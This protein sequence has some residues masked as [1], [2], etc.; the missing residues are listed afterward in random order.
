MKIVFTAQGTTWD[1]PM[2]AR[3]GRTDYLLLWDE[4]TQVLESFDNGE[5]KNEAHGAGP[6]MAK[7]LLDLKADVLITGN[8]PGENANAIL[9]KS[10]VKI[11]V[12]ATDINV[13][14][15]YNAYKAGTLRLF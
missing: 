12:G 1:S 3:F 14:E 9:G 11:Y 7:V 13:Q 6:K 15:A 8:G 5:G 2:E 4:S 10:G